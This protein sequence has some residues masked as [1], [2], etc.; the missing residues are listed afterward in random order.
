MDTLIHTANVLYLVSYTVRDILWLRVFTVIAA[1]CLVAYF[2]TRP[3]PLLTAVYWNLVFTALNIY[4]IVRLLAERRPVAL[5]Q[6]EARLHATSFESMTPRQML[7]LFRE[8]AWADHPEGRRFVRRGEKVDNLSVLSAGSAAIEID[9]NPVGE[10][11]EG[12][13]IG[14]MGFIND[15]PASVDVTAHAATRCLSWPAAKLRAYLRKN[16]ATWDAMQRTLNRE[17][18]ARLN[19]SWTRPV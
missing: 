16:P 19:R 3:E 17:L 14:T 8:G 11:G 15:D 13:F 10:I 4:W 18:V 1:L 9:G 7:N 12:G 5:N 2:L 6:E